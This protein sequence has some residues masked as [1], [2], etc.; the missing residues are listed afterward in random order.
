M[1][2]SVRSAPR[3]SCR[4]IKPSLPFTP[5]TTPGLLE[6]VK[7]DRSLIAKLMI[8]NLS[9]EAIEVIRQAIADKKD[10][11]EVE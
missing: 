6:R 3:T 2:L 9:E 4:S 7:A 11:V 8:N 1:L 5:L 10:M